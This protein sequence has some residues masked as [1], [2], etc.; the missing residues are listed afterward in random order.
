MVGLRVAM[1]RRVGHG[2]MVTLVMVV[3]LI[4]RLIVHELRLRL[5]WLTWC[6]LRLL[7]ALVIDRRISCTWP[8]SCV[9]AL[10]IPGASLSSAVAVTVG[11]MHGSVWAH[12]TN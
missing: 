10:S 9:W 3:L 8:G 12:S 4:I 1:S 6:I 7:G 2:V 5:T 11:M